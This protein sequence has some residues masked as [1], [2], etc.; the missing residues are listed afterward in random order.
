M[1]KIIKFLVLSSLIVSCARVG[2]PSGGA[3]DITP[4][5]FISSKPD[6]LATRVNPA[7][8]EIVVNF[9][10]YVLLKDIAQQVIISPS[11]RITP[12]ITPLSTARKYVT[13]RFFE[14]LLENT[15][16]TIN[17]GSSIQDNNEGNKL[18]NFSF[19]FSTGDKIDSLQVNGNVKQSLK[20]ELVEP[21]IISL[22][23]VD[24]D[25]SGK[26]SI[27]LKNKPY[28]ISRVDSLG[29]FKLDH[30]HEG[31]FRLLAFNDLNSNLIP[32]TEKEI[33]GF[34]P[35]Y[36]SPGK[37][38][39]YDIV[40]SPAKEVYKVLGA[41]QDGQGSIKVKLKGNPDKLSLTPIDPSITSYKVQH[42]PFS[43]SLYFYFNSNEIKKTEKKFRVKLLLKNNQKADTIN[44]L[45]DNTLKSDLALSPVEKEITPTS[46]YLTLKSSNFIKLI[47]KNK[48]E[49][50]K[51]K[52]PIDFSSQIDSLNAKQLI[53]KFPVSYDTEYKVT[54][55]D[56][57]CK[58]FLDQKNKDT[59]SYI[60]KTKRQNEFGNLKIQLKNKPSSKFFFQLLNEK[61][62]ILEN[63]YGSEDT[64]TFQN[65]NPGKYL[66]R[67]L[68]DDN[69]NGVWD[70]ADVDIFK[71]AE[72]TYLYP[73][74]IDVRPLWNINEVWIL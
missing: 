60:I 40:L 29:N 15:T 43:D 5:K 22:Y 54:L 41:E 17:F 61:Y 67:I 6:T 55:K 33:I 25:K 57:A 4:P 34:Y 32:D 62:D 59:L 52:Q 20:R 70:K 73:N 53:I 28:Y 23:K 38:M 48:I 47:D 66:I 18:D 31:K 16:Y 44:L 27:N 51:N 10:E 35:E 71:P 64:F 72:P 7:I 37:D 56:G 58:D 69:N 46:S 30:L 19:T 2:S 9:D 42:Q 36:I 39:R 50:S 68:V 63:I 24:K 3:K 65:L 49:V 12:S 45:Y 11:P 74:M 13:V 1:Y 21:I 14:P 26:D 8:K